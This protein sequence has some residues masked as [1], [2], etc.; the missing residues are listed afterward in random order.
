MLIGVIPVLTT[1]IFGRTGRVVAHC[2]RYPTIDRWMILYRYV[3]VRQGRT[4]S[5]FPT[6]SCG[7]EIAFRFIVWYGKNQ[8]VWYVPYYHMKNLKT[9][10]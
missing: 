6:P 10:P 8:Y 5:F 1:K 7:Y 9:N 3:L 4:T 2:T